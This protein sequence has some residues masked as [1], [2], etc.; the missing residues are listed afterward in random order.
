MKWKY[1]LVRDVEKYQIAWPTRIFSPEHQLKD[2][3]L[4]ENLFIIVNMIS[5]SMQKTNIDDKNILK[6]SAYSKG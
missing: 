3:L 2:K 5:H 1:I 6:E 4:I